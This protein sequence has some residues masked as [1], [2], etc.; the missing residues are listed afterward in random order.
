MIVSSPSVVKPSGPEDRRRR[1]VPQGRSLYGT[2]PHAPP[3]KTIADIHPGACV[4]SRH[5]T[6]DVRL[7]R[8]RDLRSHVQGLQ[9]ASHLSLKRNP[10]R[11]L[12]GRWGPWASRR[13][14]ARSGRSPP[15]STWHPYIGN[16]TAIADIH[17][18]ACV[19]SRRCND[20]CPGGH[21]T[22]LRK[23]IP[24]GVGVPVKQVSHPG[25]WREAPHLEIRVLHTIWGGVYM[26]FAHLHLNPTVADIPPR[27]CV[28]SQHITMDVKGGTGEKSRWASEC[29]GGRGRPRRPRRV[30][31]TS[32]KVTRV[33]YA[34]VGPARSQPW[35][36]SRQ[37]SGRSTRSLDGTRLSAPQSNNCRHSSTGVCAVPTYNDG[38]LRAPGCI[39]PITEKKSR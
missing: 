1:E 24:M 4:L 15:E 37:G 31:R 9:G 16:A 19:L 33:S 5:T 3:I 11:R 2:R 35:R 8:A 6:M 23:E 18:R 17:P 28:L 20:G 30:P 27:A 22:Y 25:G 34:H 29:P 32:P 38:R 10:D 13:E 14:V 12:R 39:A 26:A 7:C 36:L 21:R